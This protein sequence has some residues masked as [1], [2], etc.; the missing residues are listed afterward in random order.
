MDTYKEYEVKAML[1]GMHY[2]TSIHVFEGGDTYLDEN[3]LPM[4]RWYEPDTL[5]EL[6]RP[7]ITSTYAR[8]YGPVIEWRRAAREGTTSKGFVDYAKENGHLQALL[9]HG[10][11]K[12]TGE[13]GGG[14]QSNEVTTGGNK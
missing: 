6:A 8:R 3:N 1:L 10:Q 13:L 12:E 5:E 4:Y 9:V 11:E 7:S 14:D 2:V